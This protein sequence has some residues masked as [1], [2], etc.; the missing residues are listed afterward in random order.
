MS[1]DIKPYS[2][3]MEKPMPDLPFRIAPG[4][5]DWAMRTQSLMV[6]ANE[7]RVFTYREPYY[8]GNPDQ[9]AS[10]EYTLLTEFGATFPL[11]DDTRG[12]FYLIVLD[13]SP[14]LLPEE[15]AN[16]FAFGVVLARQ[17]LQAARR[18]SYR[19]E[20]LPDPKD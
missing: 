14:V 5:A 19:P 8:L 12:V 7:L 16:A 9:R 6:A 15:D 20:M 18:V 10:L 2:L 4:Q 1:K 11:P 3:P 13:G 17:G